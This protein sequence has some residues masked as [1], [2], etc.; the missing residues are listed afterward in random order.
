MEAITGTSPNQ[1]ERP[2]EQHGAAPPA[3]PLPPLPSA[4]EEASVRVPGA[5]RLSA[6]PQAS[7]ARPFHSPRPSPACRRR[8]SNRASTARALP[9]RKPPA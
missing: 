6:A 3:S 1:V 2:R 5:A 8:A 4:G 7:S 9:V